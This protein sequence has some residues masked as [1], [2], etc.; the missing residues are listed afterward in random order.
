MIAADPRIDD[1][2]IRVETGPDVLG[3]IVVQ[4]TNDT[5][6]LEARCY[7][8]YRI[9]KPTGYEDQEIL[10]CPDGGLEVL[11]SSVFMTLAAPVKRSSGFDR[12]VRGGG[13]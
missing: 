10:H 8:R 7:Q 9:I 1:V 4:R 2:T 5:L 3:E 12:P 13:V 6:K 11:L